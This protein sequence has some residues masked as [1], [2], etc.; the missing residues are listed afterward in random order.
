VWRRLLVELHAL[1]WWAIMDCIRGCIPSVSQLIELSFAI[2]SMFCHS[3]SSPMM[4]RSSATAELTGV[5][6]YRWSQWPVQGHVVDLDS[7]LWYSLKAWFICF[8]AAYV[9]MVIWIIAPK[10][11]TCYMVQLGPAHN[12]RRWAYP[13]YPYL[14][15]MSMSIHSMLC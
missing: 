4:V 11:V 9:M 10:R 12:N 6:I 3:P 13:R 8:K 2:R 5:D 1:S 7:Q 15:I 14:H